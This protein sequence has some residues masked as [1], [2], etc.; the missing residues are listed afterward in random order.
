MVK[1]PALSEVARAAQRRQLTVLFCDLVDSTLIA[2]RLDPEETAEVYRVFRDLCA[3]AIEAAGGYVAKYMGDGVMAYFGY[4]AAREDDAERAVHAAVKLA[5]SAP[6]ILA[7]GDGRLAVRI[8]IATGLVVVG[9][10]VGER[11]TE[12]R[13]VV[14]ETPNLAARLQSAAAP[15]EILVSS[16]TQRLAAGLFAFQD[17]GRPA[18]KGIKLRDSVWRVI[19]PRTA[20]DRFRA[21][22][23]LSNAPIIGRE[24]ELRTL[25]EA[26]RASQGGGVRV[27]GVVGEAG[28]GKSRLVDEFHRV[29]ARRGPHIWLEGGGVQ[30]FEN[31]PFHPIAQAINRRL[32]DG[33][34]L[35]SDELYER[36]ARSLS[37]VGMGDEALT[38]VAELIDVAPPGGR[39]A[40]ATAS[41]QRRRA[42]MV[43]LADWLLKTADRWPTVLAIEDL[44][45]VDPSTIEFLGTLITQ[46]SAKLL[47]V[48]TARTG[49]QAPWTGAEIRITLGPLD[50]E[51]AR[52]LVTAASAWALPPDL[53][54]KIV[55]RSG[56]VP[57]FA[58]EL[59]LLVADEPGEA[60]PPI[61]SALSDLLLAR[62]DQVG[63]AK[64]LAQIAAVL[65]CNASPSLLGAVAGLGE[66]E[67]TVAL[68]T[69]VAADLLVAHDADDRRTYAFRHALIEATAYETLLKRIRRD[70]H[71]RAA[72]AIL[73]QLPEQAERQPE[74]L[75]HHWLK[76]EEHTKAV[77]A[78]R[79]A[80]ALALGRHALREATHSAEQGISIVRSLGAAAE[81]ERDE[82]HLQDLLAEAARGI[83]GYAS[84]KVVAALERARALAV[85][86]RGVADEM[87]RLLGEW[88]ARS[89]MGDYEAAAPLGD[90]YVRLA[91]ASGG[92][93]PLGFAQMI[94]LT[95]YRQGDL[96]SAEAA[97]QTGKSYFAHPD[98]LR[99][100][101][102]AGQA[103]GSGAKIAWLLGLGDEAARRS[104]LSL[105][106]CQGAGPY[107]LVYARHMAAQLSVLRGDSAKAERL[108]SENILAAEANGYAS[109]AS[110]TR[111]ALGRAL[112]ALG[113]GGEGAA[114]IEASLLGPGERAV[115][116]SQTLY[117][118]WFA[119]A[120]AATGDAARGAAMLE[121]ALI[122][123][124][125]E[126][127]FRPETLRI[128]GDLAHADGR[129]DAAEAD[130]LAAID[131]ARSSGAAVLA[132]R[133]SSSLAGLRR[134]Q[135]RRDEM[136]QT[137]NA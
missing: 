38:L 123:N 72:E 26:W 132:Q 40:A 30:L 98:F 87:Q 42:L 44:Q 52:N 75:A 118:T 92:E 104:E 53:L 36:L 103:F 64:E 95:R 28:I 85:R 130:Y 74:V 108:A 5:R 45:W 56:G 82:I 97:F 16:L 25:L 117:L 31:T 129:F 65:G 69:L 59:A 116:P 7:G 78:W 66:P 62:L 73:K 110:L 15:N 8:G 120:L 9:D 99:Q 135:G 124:P 61:P 3:A 21:R 77:A 68:E 55:V 134:S 12:E 39:K 22:R 20:P 70:L 46:A 14:G 50:R 90:A 125:G 80:A 48:Y 71:R 6:E 106:V 105:D 32:A 49:A 27:A 4:P 131:F 2:T 94:L 89:S 100:P 126:I 34:P 102:A 81:L 101:G 63:S 114:L 41:D 47:I 24:A 54:E 109:L 18:L 19:G 88:A 29:I 17:V 137:D 128:R 83:E 67:L 113:R 43:A 13:D 127:Y 96:A 76:A 57:L 84:P 122:V 37:L 119:E 23:S 136:R 107:D 91:R 121:E 93:G 86:H 115:R 112:V 11:A 1:S 58:E 79:S 133:A 10:L 51:S 60:S 33:Q 35:G 111:I